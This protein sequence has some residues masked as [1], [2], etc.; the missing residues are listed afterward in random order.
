MPTEIHPAIGSTI[1]P[2]YF[3]LTTS[4]VFILCVIWVFFFYTASETYS[5]KRN[6]EIEVNF[7]TTKKIAAQIKLAA[8]E[9]PGSAAKLRLI[10]PTHKE[11]VFLECELDAVSYPRCCGYRQK[12]KSP[13]SECSDVVHKSYW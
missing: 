3:K 9:S 8:T 2:Q 5:L 10:H 11:V 6:V 4:I 1:A 7:P 13:S 12:H